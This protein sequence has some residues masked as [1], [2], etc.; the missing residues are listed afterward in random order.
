MSSEKKPV[1]PQHQLTVPERRDDDWT[2]LL[3]RTSQGDESAFADLYDRSSALVNG[4]VFRMLRDTAAAEDVT[5][6]VYM[7]VWRQATRYDAAR[8]SVRAWL[9]LL[10]R[11]RALDSLRASASEPRHRDPLETASMVPSTD[12]TPEEHSAISHRRLIVQRACAGLAAEQ[13]Q[14]I[15]LAYFGGL[16]H[17]E[18]AS[19]LGQP[20]GTIKTRIRAGM[21]RLRQALGQSGVEAW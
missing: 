3:E 5:L 19:T 4:L 6:D 2:T 8:G 16:S 7:Q 20:L 11:S 21:T 13:R 1:R 15:E 17:S 12:P 9:L 18:I 14:A 10:A